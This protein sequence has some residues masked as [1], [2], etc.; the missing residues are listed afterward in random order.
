MRKY[1][2]CINTNFLFFEGDIGPQQA[3]FVL[4]HIEMSLGQ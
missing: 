4:Y 3:T 2:Q 1:V